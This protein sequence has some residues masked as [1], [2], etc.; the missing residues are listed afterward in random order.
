MV[1]S[2]EQESDSSNVE[3][4]HINNMKISSLMDIKSSE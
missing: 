1:F 4:I 3:T 2:L